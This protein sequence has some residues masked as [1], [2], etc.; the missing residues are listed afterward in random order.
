MK[1]RK[2]AE[3]RFAKLGEDFKEG[4]ILTITGDAIE[5]EGE[6]GTQILF[7]VRTMKGDEK[8]L[9]FNATSR[10]RLFDAYGEDSEGWVGKEVRVHVVK[11]NV[12]GKMKDVVYLCAPDQEMFPEG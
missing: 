9:S 8:N 2:T 5:Q 4:D 3:G 1:F 11:Q 6:F 7:S 10:N 12:G